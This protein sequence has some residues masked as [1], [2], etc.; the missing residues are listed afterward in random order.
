MDEDY[1]MPGLSDPRAVAAF[2]GKRAPCT[3]ITESAASI[4]CRSEELA[5]RFFGRFNTKY[6]D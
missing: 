1:E 2:A 3:S 5:I 6:L 4:I